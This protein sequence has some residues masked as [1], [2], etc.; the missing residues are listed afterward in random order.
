MHRVASGY[1]KLVTCSNLPYLLAVHADTCTNFVRAV[2][3][4]LVL[5]CADFH[6]IRHCSV[7]KPVGEVTTAAGHKIDVVGE[8]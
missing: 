4:D 3:H 7:Y 6:S 1:L 2:G 8:S 5:L